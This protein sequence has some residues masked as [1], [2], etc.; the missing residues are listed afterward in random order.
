[1]VTLA[2][3]W[4]LIVPLLGLT[5]GQLLPGDYHW[6]VKVVHLLVGMGAMGQGDVL[7]A[8]IKQAPARRP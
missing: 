5:Q 3:V 2:V 1:L 4:G 7:A 6:V 8:R